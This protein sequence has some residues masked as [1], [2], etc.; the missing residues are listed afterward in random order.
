MRSGFCVAIVL[1]TPPFPYDRKTVNEA[2]GLPIFFDGKLS[3]EEQS[4]LYYGEVGLASGLLVTSGQYG[5]T[6]VATGVAKNIPEAQKKAC[7]LADRVIVPNVRYRR[8][9]GNGLIAGG[10]YARVERFNL[11]DR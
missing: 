4:H 3:T 1:T 10:D 8:D 2:V 6:M 5:W 9:I 7:D 11:F